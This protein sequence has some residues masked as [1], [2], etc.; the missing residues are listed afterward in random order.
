[1][2]SI[3]SIDSVISK[4]INGDKGVINALDNFINLGISIIEHTE[5]LREEIMDFDEIYQFHLTDINFIFWIKISQGKITYNKG[6]NESATLQIYMTRDLLLKILKREIGG[7][8]AYMKGLIKL[9][10]DLT[11]AFKIK[12]FLRHLINYLE[13]FSKKNH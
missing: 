10:G 11:Q 13:L 6:K 3:K 12:T 5:E 4:L 1:L 7:T 8:E 2:L 9:N